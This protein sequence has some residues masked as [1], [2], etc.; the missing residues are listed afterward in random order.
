MYVGITDPEPDSRTREHTR[1]E[2]VVIILCVVIPELSPFSD[3]RYS[4]EDEHLLQR[5]SN[6][7]LHEPSGVVSISHSFHALLGN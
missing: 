2:V 6:Y 3:K 1:L 4:G 5:P 7:L